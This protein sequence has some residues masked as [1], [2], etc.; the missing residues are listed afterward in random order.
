MLVLLKSGAENAHAC[1]YSR[2]LQM[3]DGAVHGAVHGAIHGAVHAWRNIES[4]S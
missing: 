2:D 4:M 1:M 3:H